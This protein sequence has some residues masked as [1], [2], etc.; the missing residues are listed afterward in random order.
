[1]H[2]EPHSETEFLVEFIFLT[3]GTISLVWIIDFLV[4]L[5][6]ALYYIIS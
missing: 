4:V 6:R 1:M 5:Y 3:I 2:I